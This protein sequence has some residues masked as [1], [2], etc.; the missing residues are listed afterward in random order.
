ML[1]LKNSHSTKRWKVKSKRSHTP[2]QFWEVTPLTRCVSFQEFPPQTYIHISIYLCLSCLNSRI[3]RTWHS[4]LQ[5]AFS[6]NSVHWPSF[7]MCVYFVPVYSVSLH[8][9]IEISFTSLGHLKPTLPP[10]NIQQIPPR[11]YF[12]LCKSL[13]SSLSCYSSSH[14][15]LQIGHRWLDL[16]SYSPSVWCF[17]LLNVHH[18]ATQTLYI[19]TAS[20][21]PSSRSEDCQAGF[22]SMR[23]T[24]A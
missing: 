24:P 9:W 19:L 11:S 18:G 23:R 13:H 4:L 7:H 3:N 16:L 2:S 17:L 22:T 21:T 6:L 15:H 10:S 12:F 8:K 20:P 14:L 1:T 5:L